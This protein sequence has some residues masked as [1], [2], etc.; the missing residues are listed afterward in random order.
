[1][2]APAV[3]RERVM[4]RGLR[5]NKNIEW[6]FNYV[7]GFEETVKGTAVFSKQVP[8]VSNA[9]ISMHIHIGASFTY[10]I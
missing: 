9:S 5:P 6:S 8:D 2:L 4:L 10:K 3:I 7:H 1:M